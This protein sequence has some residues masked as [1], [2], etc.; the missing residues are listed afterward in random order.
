M[1][2]VQKLKILCPVCEKPDG[3]LVSEDGAACICSRIEQGSVKKVGTG[4]F[5]GGWLHILGDFKPKK[6]TEPPKPDINWNLLAVKHGRQLMEHA[7]EFAEFCQSKRINPIAALRF[8]VGWDEDWITIPI[9]GSDGKISGIQRRRGVFKRFLEHSS[10]GVFV[11]SAFFQ[12]KCKT[13][14]IC[15]G[16]TDTVTAI[17]YGFNAV[18]KLNS[19]VGNEQLKYFIER[20][21]CERIVI[22]ADNNENNVGIEG[23]ESTKEYLSYLNMPIKI[24]LTP[25]KDLKDCYTKG[26]SLRDI[27]GV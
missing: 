3:C 26:M 9:Y 8:F 14:A 6:Y 20:I 17:Q 1:L 12:Y 22:F 15:E 27:F 4:P 18:G 23:A 21:G 7:H 2:R 19:H 5:Y 11:P 13:L 10:A 16:W 25:E 24:I